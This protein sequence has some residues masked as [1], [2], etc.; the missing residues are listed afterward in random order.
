MVQETGDKSFGRYRPVRKIGEGPVTLVYLA[1]DEESGQAAAIK[2]PPRGLSADRA[3]VARFKTA[4]AA[5]VALRHPHLVTIYEADENAEH[6]PYIAMELLQGRP[7]TDLMSERVRL[8][9]PSVVS[10]VEQIAGA[11]DY[12]HEQKLVLGDLVPA[13][14]VVDDAGHATLTNFGLGRSLDVRA[15]DEEGAGPPLGNTSYMALEQIQ[16]ERVTPAA[17]GYA[18]GVITYQMLAGRLPFLGGATDVLQAQLNERLQPVHELAFGVFP[19]VSVILSRQLSKQP[20]QRF[21]SARAFAAALREAVR[22]QAESET[23]V[24]EGGAADEETLVWQGEGRKLPPLPLLAGVVGVLLLVVA[25]ATF[26]L[27]RAG[28]KPVRAGTKSGPTTAAANVIDAATTLCSPDFGALN[29]IKPVAQVPVGPLLC[30]DNFHGPA[31]ADKG[32]IPATSVPN[33]EARYQDGS[34][35]ISELA[36]SASSRFSNPNEGKPPSFLAEVRA[37]I[38]DGA[39]SAVFGL[40]FRNTD[41]GSSSW[42]EISKTG[43]FDVVRFE[44]GQP[45]STVLEGDIKDNCKPNTAVR[46]GAA[47]TVDVL[48]NDN[49]VQIYMNGQ[50]VSDLPD[51]D[52][53]FSSQAGPQIFL[54]VFTGKL[55]ATAV[56]FQSFRLWS[57]PQSAPSVGSG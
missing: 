35:L 50:L 10:V 36:A 57:L 25:V 19:S 38:I 22:G 52:P 15:T 53:A 12:L 9:L 47:N 45:Q 24:T 40:T 41:D 23:L 21:P 30:A 7:L 17:D 48:V 4:G 56:Q 28:K 34:L 26:L 20:A 13:N 37:V 5:A 46:V 31:K 33:A 32:W 42:F 44:N 18:L 11:L 1:R 29:N 43:C 49:L 14:I 51:Q 39:D 3:F 54:R 2:V 55:P 8:P 6:V 16:G 27:L